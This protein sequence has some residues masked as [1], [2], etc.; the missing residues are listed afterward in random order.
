MA[1]TKV[2]E[3]CVPSGGSRGNA[4]PSLAS[5]DRLLSLVP[6]SLPLLHSQLW[7]GWGGGPAWW[8]AFASFRGMN[9]PT[10]ADVSYPRDITERG[11]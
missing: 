5:R 8:G 4:L 11:V 7:W 2:S 6:I 1:E 9:T 3:G 10:E